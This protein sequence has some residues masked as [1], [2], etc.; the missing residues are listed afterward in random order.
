MC[1]A[2]P[3]RM[4]QWLELWT[5]AFFRFLIYGCLGWCVEVFFTGVAS[6]VFKRDRSATGQTYLWMHPVWGLSC[7]ALERVHRLFAGAPLPL[8]GVAYLLVIYATEFGF[9]WILRRLLGR[10][11]WD[12]GT[13]GV[14]VLGLVRLDYAP[15][16]LLAAFLFEPMSGAV[17]ALT[18]GL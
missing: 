18:S 16:W 15:A 1:L 17:I 3:V 12:Y 11:P 14:N 10:C 2:A 8:R 4:Q 5:N 6:A 7:L 9:G 13:R